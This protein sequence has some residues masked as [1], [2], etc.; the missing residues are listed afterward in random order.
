MSL[1]LKGL[2]AVCETEKEGKELLPKVVNT[3]SNLEEISEWFKA[4]HRKVLLARGGKI[5][6]VRFI[7]AKLTLVPKRK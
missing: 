2:K 7:G 1:M 3:L 5:V 4:R 6:P